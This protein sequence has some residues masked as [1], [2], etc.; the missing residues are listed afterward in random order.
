MGQT[1]YTLP[2]GPIH[3]ALKEPTMFKLTIEGEIV[4]KVDV[5]PGIN[6]RGIE[7]IGMRRNPLQV[8]HLAERICGICSIVHQYSFALASEKAAGITEIPDRA[9]YIR[10]IMA[11]LERIHSHMLWAG[12]AAHE[13]GFDTLLH[14]TW[15]VRE[16][17]QDILELISGNR[18]NYAMYIQGGV[19]RDIP[20]YKIKKIRKMLD[21]YRAEIQKFADAFLEDPVFKH[22]TV[23]V[24]VLTYEDAVAT[25]AVGP[26][27][28]GSGV[29]KDVRIDQPF[30][31]YAD[32][33]LNYILPEMANYPNNGDTYAKTV[34]RLL[35]VIQAMDI[36]EYC[37][38]NM[39]P[40]P[41]RWEM[42]NNKLLMYM[43]KAEGEALGLNEAPRGEMIHYV[44]LK[45][46]DENVT[47][48]KVRASTY[49]NIL[50]WTKMLPGSQIADV[51]I[52]AAAVDPCIGCMDRVTV[53]DADTKKEKLWTKE[54][55]YRESVRKT[56]RLMR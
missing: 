23:N 40:G 36:I 35:E 8:L 54:D 19:R 33:D 47:V 32:I 4:T 31:G 20:D 39:P 14:W 27:T 28:R 56:R 45:A 34:V 3:P 30:G 5:Q 52:V 29:K 22:R 42:N 53:V 7:F 17:V 25:S 13:L 12:V 9:Q 38:D 6:H 41:Y 55:F 46:G 51:S 10:T 49:N 26:T 18:V 15:K 50:A 21:G 37:L 2:I 43:K 16:W 11:E 44:R 1:P 24:G 48:W